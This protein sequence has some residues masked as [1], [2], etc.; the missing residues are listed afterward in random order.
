MP[1]I[2][3]AQLERVQAGVASMH[4]RAQR[5]KEAIERQADNMKKVGEIVGGAAA[6]GFVR[7]KYEK[8]GSKFVIPGT[9]ID[10]Q[11]AIGVAAVGAALFN[12]AGKYDDDLL[13]V[14]SGI[15]AGYA[16]DVFRAYGKSDSISLVAGSP[17]LVGAGSHLGHQFG[18][19]SVGAVPM[20]D[21]LRSA[22]A[23]G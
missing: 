9:T 15:L 4:A 3:D 20:N 18:Q 13:N 6:I 19:P 10:G 1:F 21:M 2:S 7:G 12:V 11:L 22:L 17:M 8:D 16:Q 5:A 14:G 23:A